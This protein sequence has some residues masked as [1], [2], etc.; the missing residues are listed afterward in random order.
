MDIGVSPFDSDTNAGRNGNS[1][2]QPADHRIFKLLGLI[3]N[4]MPADKTSPHATYLPG[5]TSLKLI[6]QEAVAAAASGGSSANAANTTNTPDELLQIILSSATSYAASGRS[7]SDVAWMT[8][9]DYML[10]SQ[11]QRQQQHQQQQQLSHQVLM[12]D[13]IGASPHSFPAM[14]NGANNTANVI[15]STNSNDS[16]PLSFDPQAAASVLAQQSQTTAIPT[17]DPNL[18]LGSANNGLG[19]NWTLN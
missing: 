2:N 9:R 4:Y 13:L 16:L 1:P 17:F 3:V 8:A 10:L 7:E 19:F 18:P 14:T 15:H 11:Q 6:L 12:A 5:F